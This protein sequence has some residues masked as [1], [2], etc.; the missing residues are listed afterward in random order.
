MHTFEVSC[1]IPPSVY[2]YLHDNLPNLVNVSQCVERTNYYSAKGVTQI[3][4]R[5]HEYFKY[6][7]R[8]QKYFL[9]LR[10]NPSIIMGDG[11]VFLL[12]MEKYTSAEVLAKL[13]KR[14]SLIS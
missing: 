1:N 12:D 6:G 7:V 10:C 3:E 4:L 8:L 14:I 13:Q 11:K 5:I 2:R 9:I